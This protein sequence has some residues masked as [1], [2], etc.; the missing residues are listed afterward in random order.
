MNK[1]IT[2]L[3]KI[4][5]AYAIACKP[6]CKDLG[7]TQTAFDVLMFL[8]N[9]PEYKTAS[10]IVEIRHLKANLVSVNVDRLVSEGYLMR[11]AIDGDRRKT[12]LTC[13]DK[14]SPVIERGR[15]MQRAFAETLFSDMSDEVRDMF[16]SAIGVIDKNLNEMLKEK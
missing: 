8:A 16:V 6:L 12:Q 1:S 15:E 9:N 2:I 3:R 7:L 10:E 14:A 5:L 4:D 13:T 11:S